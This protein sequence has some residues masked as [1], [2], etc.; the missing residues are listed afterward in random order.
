MAK[1]KTTFDR[2]WLNTQ[3]NP[4]FSDWVERVQGDPYAAR[5][6]L[7][8]SR[9]I[10]LSN[11]GRQALYSHSK[12]KKHILAVSAMKENRKLCF[13]SRP[14]SSSELQDN[15]ISCVV[16][17]TQASNSS[18]SQLTP[19]TSSVT[20]SDFVISNATTDAENR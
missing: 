14:S 15:G 12:Y 18:S 10:Q 16:E 13:V 11:M 19:P 9:P 3:L 8:V 6:K 2:S 17:S 7:C 4:Q 1:A 20:V 5:C